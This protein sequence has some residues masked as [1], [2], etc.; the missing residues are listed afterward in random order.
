MDS[1]AGVSI[2]EYGVRATVFVQF[3]FYEGAKKV[4]F[5]I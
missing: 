2:H 5:K 3:V 1:Q 4:F